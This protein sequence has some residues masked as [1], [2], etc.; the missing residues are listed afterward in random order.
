M[1]GSVSMDSN[2]PRPHLFGVITL[3]QDVGIPNENN[4]YNKPKHRHNYQNLYR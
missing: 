2:R 1:D 4:L 3:N